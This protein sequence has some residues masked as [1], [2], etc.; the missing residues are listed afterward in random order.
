MKTRLG[1][2]FIFSLAIAFFDLPQVLAQTRQTV[3][4]FPNGQYAYKWSRPANTYIAFQK[5][6]RKIVGAVY[7][8]YTDNLVCLSGTLNGN[9]ITNVTNATSNFTYGSKKYTFARGNSINL[10][11]LSR[12]QFNQINSNKKVVQICTTIFRNRP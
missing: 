4:N 12:A 9:I 1:L 7:E 10:S 5:T 11:S 8:R 6:G 2:T 3:Q